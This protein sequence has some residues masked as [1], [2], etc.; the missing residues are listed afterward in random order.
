MSRYTA[1]YIICYDISDG[2]RLRKLARELEKIA[3]RIQ[4]SVFFAQS[5]KQEELFDIMEMIDGIIDCK[6]DD[7]RIYTV[8]DPG[9]KLGDAIDLREP[10]V[11]T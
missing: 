9:M 5:V 8:I 6:E 7:V 2:K 4:Y 3:I 11:L 1:D 10:V